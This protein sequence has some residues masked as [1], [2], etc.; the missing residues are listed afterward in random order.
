MI[1]GLEAED[2]TSSRLKLNLN[3][4]KEKNMKTDNNNNMKS[5]N[6]EN[7]QV[8]FFAKKAASKTLVIKTRIQAGAGGRE[9]LVK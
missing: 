8:P 9:E 1:V 2:A 7:K 4:E 5:D 3:F 6:K